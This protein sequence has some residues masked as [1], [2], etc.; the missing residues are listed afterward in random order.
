MSN[1]GDIINYQLRIFPSKQI[2]HCRELTEQ[3]SKR[4]KIVNE[5]RDNRPRHSL[6][7]KKFIEILQKWNFYH[8]R[9]KSTKN[10]KFACFQ[11]VFASIFLLKS[12][13]WFYSSFKPPKIYSARLQ[14]SVF[15]GLRKYFDKR[16]NS[17][18]ILSSLFAGKKSILAAK[19]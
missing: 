9:N 17:L 5:N 6:R 8:L 10:N 13:L 15:M 11:S 4:A 2:K 12:N 3:S 7:I 14:V 16:W 1:Q 18:I 19:C